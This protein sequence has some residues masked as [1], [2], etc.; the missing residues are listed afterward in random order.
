MFGNTAQ[1]AKLAIRESEALHATHA[2]CID[3]GLV[4][5]L[6]LGDDQL[7]QL[8]EEPRIDAG[9]LVQL[10]GAHSQQ[11]GALELVNALRCGSPQRATKLFLRAFNES[12]IHEPFTDGPATAAV[13]E[14]TQRLLERFLEGAA[15]RHRLAD[16]LHLGGKAR[17]GRRE[18][19]EGEA[20][21]LH[22]HVVE[23]R[24]EAGWRRLGNVVRHFIER[25]ANGELRTDAR[26]RK[27]GRLGGER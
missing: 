14:R 17:I 11:H 7:M 12:V 19:L 8:V 22:D 27:A 3:R 9:D 16:R 24:L 18:L 4:L 21:A 6:G 15:D 2:F 23:H 10:Y 26:N 20:R 5:V 13:L 1:C 25:V